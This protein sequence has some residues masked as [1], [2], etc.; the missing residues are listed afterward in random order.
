MAN[1]DFTTPAQKRRNERDT[2]IRK[3]FDYYATQGHSK[4][5]IIKAMAASGK[6]HYTSFNAIASSLERTAKQNS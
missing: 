2:E 5:R 6:F 1:I 3:A 4:C